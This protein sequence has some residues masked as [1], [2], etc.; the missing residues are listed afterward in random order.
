MRVVGSSWVTPLML[1]AD[2]IRV[3][4]GEMVLDYG[5]LVLQQRVALRNVPTGSVT[6]TL[7]RDDM[8]NFTV[9]PLMKQAA[10]AAVQGKVRESALRHRQWATG[11]GAAA[12]PRLQERL[13]TARIAS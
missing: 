2:R 6:I 1:T 5:A 12:A 10:A 13:H 11:R 3:E 8:A 7:L 4:V 9:H